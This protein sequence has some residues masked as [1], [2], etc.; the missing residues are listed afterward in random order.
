MSPDSAPSWRAHFVT[1]A[2]Y[3]HWANAVLFA[4]LDALPVPVLSQHQGLFFGSVQH[5]VDHMLRVSQ[6]WLARL[7][8]RSPSVDYRTLQHADWQALRAALQGELRHLHDWLNAQPETFFA[9]RFG[10]VGGDGQTRQMAVHDALTHL[11]TH[12][13][14]HRGQLSAV[15]T[16][17]GGPCPEMDFVYYR[18]A[19]DGFSAAAPRPAAG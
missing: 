18:R 3:Q 10:Y 5:T 1:Q 14:H 2:D 12:Y 16:R 11:F 15:I 17:L 9:G 6:V 8:G 19:R 13:V 7:K 4:A